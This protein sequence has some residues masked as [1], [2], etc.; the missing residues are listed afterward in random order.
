MGTQRG[1]LWLDNILTL[2]LMYQ[3]GIFWFPIAWRSHGIATSK[4]IY[5]HWVPPPSPPKKIKYDFRGEHRRQHPISRGGLWEWKYFGSAQ[6]VRSASRPT[7]WLRSSIRCA[8]GSQ[9]PAG[10]PHRFWSPLVDSESVPAPMDS[11]MALEP[12]E[13]LDHVQSG[14]FNGDLSNL[15]PLS[16]PQWEDSV[17]GGMRTPLRHDKLGKLDLITINYFSQILL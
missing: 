9:G 14:A 2:T 16:S 3:N 7:S 1:N 10:S 5:K 11:E 8:N 17:T 4:I 13:T 6:P 12:T 15:T